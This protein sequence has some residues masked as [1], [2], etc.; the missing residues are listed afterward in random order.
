MSIFS[1][2]ICNDNYPP[3]KKT[4]E[5]IAS[6]ITLYNKVKGKFCQGLANR[7][8]KEKQLFLGLI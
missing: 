6:E 5:H 3:G 4:V 2:D 7:R 8:E 1:C